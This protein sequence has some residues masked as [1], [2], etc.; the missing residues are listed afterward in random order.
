MCAAPTAVSPSDACL[1]F[2]EQK[3]VCL[4]ARLGFE[5]TQHESEAEYYTLVLHVC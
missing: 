4:F 1:T 5:L 3:C 2:F